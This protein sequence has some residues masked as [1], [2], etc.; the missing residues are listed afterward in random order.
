MTYSVKTIRPF[1]VSNAKDIGI[2]DVSRRNNYSMHHQR[3]WKI[4]IHAD[5][6]VFVRVMMKKEIK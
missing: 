1:F 5:H 4:Q 2:V 6:E 3:L